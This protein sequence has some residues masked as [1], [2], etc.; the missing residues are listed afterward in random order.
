[1]ECAACFDKEEASLRR[2]IEQFRASTI[3]PARRDRQ[4]ARREQQIAANALMRANAW[5]N[6]AAASYNLGKWGEARTF[7]EKLTEDERFGER[8]Q[9][10]LKRLEIKN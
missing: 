7:A 9:D 5:F 10:L 2:E 4:I 6:A 8:A 3:P 1:M